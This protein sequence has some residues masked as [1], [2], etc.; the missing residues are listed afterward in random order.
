[1][2]TFK[3]P[4]R[5]RP[6][7]QQQVRIIAT[8]HPPID[9]FE[10][11]D[12]GEDELRGVW[13]L[14]ELTNP[15]LQQQAGR[16][17]RVRKGDLISGPNASIVMAAF[18]HIGFPS[19]FT[20]GSFGIYYAGRDQE[21]AVRETV[22]HRE[23]DARDAG[24]GPDVFQ[25]RAYVGQV[26]KSCYDVRGREYDHLHDPDVN[27]YGTAQAF[28]KQLLGAD[29]DAWGIVYRSVRH[30][31]GDCLAALRPPCVSLPQT[32]PLLAYHWDGTRVTHVDEL[33]TLYRF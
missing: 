14:A 31:G 19:R 20:D 9:L 4:R 16:L 17:N 26:Q 2:N 24:L 12:L 10:S 30:P 8:R 1:M 3:A 11:L 28:T 25:M 21:T 27:R 5:Y 7:W 29:P 22:F 23:L 13:A 15:R 18:T 32:G 33:E 6:R